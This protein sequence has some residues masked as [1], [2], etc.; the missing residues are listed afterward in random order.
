MIDTN[1][2]TTNSSSTR[3]SRRFD[4]ILIAASVILAASLAYLWTSKPLNQED[5]MKKTSKE[6]VA[7]TPSSGVVL[8]CD[9][10]RLSP[11]PGAT[12]MLMSCSQHSTDQTNL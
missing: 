12:L 2:A 9:P 5:L 10:D 4:V 8:V 3:P 11:S 6:R 7:P 1:L